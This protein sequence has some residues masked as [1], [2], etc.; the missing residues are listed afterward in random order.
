MD[1]DVMPDSD[2]RFRIDRRSTLK[3]LGAGAGAVAGIGAFSGTA[4]AWSEFHACFR[5]CSE[6]WMITTESE[7]GRDPQSVA[8]VIVSLGDD[9]KCVEVEFTEANATTIPGKFGDSPVVKYA[10]GGDYKVLGVIEVDRTTN[11]GVWCVTVN[12]NNC[13][14]KSNTPDVHDADCVPDGHPVCP[15]G[16][17]CGGT[18][19]GGGEQRGGPPQQ[20]GGTS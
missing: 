2:D 13:A 11:E 20:L 17:F 7:I 15:E 16:D 4:A 9:V 12:E 6:V 8:K 1:R 18:G 3:A 19:K 5:G 10:P 14:T